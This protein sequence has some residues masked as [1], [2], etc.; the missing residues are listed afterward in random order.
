M[1]LSLLVFG[2]KPACSD[3]AAHERVVA[4]CARQHYRYAPFGHLDGSRTA[5]PMRAVLGTGR[6]TLYLRIRQ[7]GRVLGTQGVLCD[8]RTDP[9]NLRRRAESPPIP[10]RGLARGR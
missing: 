6:P 9:E 3:A 1:F 10:A 5:P 8:Q 4:W 7:P 2:R